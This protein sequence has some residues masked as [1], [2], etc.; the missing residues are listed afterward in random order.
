MSIK[1]I[2]KEYEDLTRFYLPKKAYSIIRLDG[3]AFHSFTKRFKRPFDDD[4]I[5]LMNET[6]LSLCREIAGVK[7]AYV[8]SDEISLILSDLDNENTQLWFDGNIQKIA[9]VSS[10]IAT[11]HFNKYLIGHIIFKEFKKDSDREKLIHL[12]A[13][14]ADCL[15]NSLAYFDCRVFSIPSQE[16]VINYLIMRQKDAIKNSVSMFSQSFFSHQKLEGKNTKEKIEMCLAEGGD[17]NSIEI[18]QQ[19]GRI[20][21]KNQINKKIKNPKTGNQ[22]IT[23]RHEWKIE[24]APLF[25]QNLDY[26]KN[27]I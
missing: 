14:V 2:K 13:H 16:E 23:I 25:K 11:A 26:I 24:E 7:M 6:C 15:R 19:R 22:E 20:A 1:D 4:F 5:N 17:W 27:K 3:K 21:H 8:Q 18:G 12:S 10:S 9:S